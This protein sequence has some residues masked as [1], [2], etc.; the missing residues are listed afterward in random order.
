MCLTLSSGH[1]ADNLALLFLLILPSV[2]DSCLA[3]FFLKEN[4]SGSK[5]LSRDVF[6]WGIKAKNAFLH[7]ELHNLVER[8]CMRSN[9]CLDRTSKF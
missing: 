9:F 5:G 8:I 3:G 6:I 4:D 7:F 1:L 2:G